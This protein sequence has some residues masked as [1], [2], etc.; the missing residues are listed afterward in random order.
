MVSLNIQLLD[1]TSS[2]DFYKNKLD[3]LSKQVDT[4][5]LEL[6]DKKN[7]VDKFEIASK[8]W[9]IIIFQRGVNRV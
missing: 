4:L 1:A 2:R 6:F 3:E 5:K 7:H 8:K 9:G